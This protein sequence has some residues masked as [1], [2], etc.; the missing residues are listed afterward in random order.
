MRKRP[1]DPNQLAYMTVQIA[2]G[3]IKEEEPAADPGG[4]HRW[5]TALLTKLVSCLPRAGH[6]RPTS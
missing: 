1:R 6:S 2:S 4:S 5:L 3:Q